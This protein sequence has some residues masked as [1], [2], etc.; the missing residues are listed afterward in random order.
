[1]TSAVFAGLVLSGTLFVFGAVYPWISRPAAAATFLLFLIAR[2]RLFRDRTFAV[3]LTI[4][5]V[6]AYGWLQLAP[7]PPSFVN[8]LSPASDAFHR[9]VDLTPFDPMAWRP[10]SLAPGASREALLILTAGA[11]FYWVTR[12]S[13][14]ASGTRF[15]ARWI[16]FTGS[17]CVVLAA[18]SPALFPN[19]LIYGFWHPLDMHSD[20]MGPII[21]RNHFAAWMLMAAPIVAGY[22]AARARSHWLAPTVKESGLRAL[23]DARAFFIVGATALISGGVL[24]SKSRAG[25][26]G[27]SAAAL[28]ALIGGW[29]QF[30]RR[31]RFGLVSLVLGLLTGALMISNPA[32]VVNRLGEAGEDSWGGRPMIWQ[33]T[34]ALIARYPITGVGYGAY[35]G[36]MPLYQPPPRGMMMNHAHNQYLEIAAEGGVPGI[37]LFAAA[38]VML[39]RLHIRRQRHDRSAHRYLRSGALVGLAGLAVQSIWETPLLTPAVLWLAAAAAGI[40]TS[41]PPA[42]ASTS[43]VEFPVGRA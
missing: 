22:L 5:F 11:M 35:E 15:L 10:L 20:P 41:S 24:M 43:S 25:L 13:L 8:A 28:F 9:S 21:S 31:G 38:L 32:R 34:R 39:V 30:G 2:P 36:A 7:L 27:F 14:G 4:L 3:D 26:I 6:L 42:S 18:L 29:R 33:T 17:A 40:A 1:M 16:A 37:L 19:G 23:T 12:D